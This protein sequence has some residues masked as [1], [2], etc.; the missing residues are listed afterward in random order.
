MHYSL[1]GSS[2][3]GI[4]QARI[5]EWVAYP[6]FRGS[7][8]P[9]NWT[10]VSCIAGRF[11]SSWATRE[12]LSKAKSPK[13]RN[14]WQ[15]LQQKNFPH[16]PSISWSRQVLVII[17]YH[18]SSPAALCEEL[19]FFL[20][21]KK[22]DH[23]DPSCGKIGLKLGPGFSSE[24]LTELQTQALSFVAETVVLDDTI[25]TPILTPNFL[26]PFLK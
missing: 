7:S 10:G 13:L 15:V 18:L 22:S 23:G 24:V 26:F 16:V 5:L 20:W 17:S 8:W 25:V 12:D 6:F 19:L 14:I 21:T 9:R 11:F 4:L 3:H 2:V 1:T